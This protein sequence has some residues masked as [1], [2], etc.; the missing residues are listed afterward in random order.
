MGGGKGRTFPAAGHLV[1]Q[2]AAFPLART[3]RGPGSGSPISLRDRETP[4]WT[5]SPARTTVRAPPPTAQLRPRGGKP[6]A[7]SVPGAGRQGAR[8]SSVPG[9][10]SPLPAPS[11]PR[12]H[13]PRPG[14]GGSRIVI[15][16][17]WDAY[18]KCA[19]VPFGAVHTDFPVVGE[20]DV[21]YNRKAET[22]AS[23]FAAA[24][25][26]DPVEALE[27]SGFVSGGDPMSGILYLNHE[28]MGVPRYCY[29][30]VA[31]RPA[32]FN[33]IVDEVSERLLQ[34][35]AIAACARRSSVGL[36]GNFA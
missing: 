33:R 25:A 31:A 4:G 7:S 14:P 16:V 9:A 2:V 29:L 18:G 21:F 27:Y 24:R 20:C 26:V 32:V 12:R 13:G 6:P 36:S 19:A 8:V 5:P 34:E 23:E 35:I 3:G 15:R 1:V 11:P 17:L 10:G 30:H 28:L 22:G